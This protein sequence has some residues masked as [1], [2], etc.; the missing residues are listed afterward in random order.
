MCHEAGKVGVRVR[1]EGRKR[2]SEEKRREE[3]D[4]RHGGMKMGGG[5]GKQCRAQ[6]CT[7]VHLR[8]RE[9]E[10]QKTEWV[11]RMW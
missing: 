2:R 3:R 9:T 7:R 10:K 11:L 5:R 4:E 6:G 8:G 1:I